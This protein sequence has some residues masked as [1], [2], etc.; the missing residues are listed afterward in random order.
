MTKQKI[1]NLSNKVL[2]K[3][4]V[5][6]P[7]RGF[8]FTPNFLPNK[9]QLKN[10]EQPFSRKLCLLEIFFLMSRKMRNIL[11]I[12]LLKK[13]KKTAFNPRKTEIKY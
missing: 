10:D 12:L 9:V 7:C 4:N 1:F 3:Q 6:V 5:K 8:K 13:K 11:M 2:S